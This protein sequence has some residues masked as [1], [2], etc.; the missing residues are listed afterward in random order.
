MTE[1]TV[2]ARNLHLRLLQMS[3][4]PTDEPAQDAPP[5]IDTQHLQQQLHQDVQQPEPTRKRK[6][7]LFYILFYLFLTY[8]FQPKHRPY[9]GLALHVTLV[10]QDAAKSCPV[11]S[12]LRPFPFLPLPHFFFCSRVVSNEAWVLLV[13]IQIL[14]HKINKPTITLQVHLT[15]AAHIHTFPHFCLQLPQMSS[16]RLHHPCMQPCKAPQT[17]L[18]N[19]IM[20]T[21]V[22]LLAP[23]PLPSAQINALAISQTRRPPPSLAIL[24]VVISTSAPVL[25]SGSIPVCR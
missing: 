2:V 23:P 5:S 16:L 7:Q 18:I 22:L 6:F 1:S 17:C 15:L 8:P 4:I 9:G 3:A 20:T 25:P 12:V 19:N 11:R 10:K 24:P 13:P 14:M 21:M